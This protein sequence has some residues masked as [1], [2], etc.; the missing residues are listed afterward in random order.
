MS[1]QMFVNLAVADLPRAVAFF[2][3]LGFG[4]D[5]QFTDD[6]AT[7]MVVGSDNFVM[8]LTRPFFATFT[9]RPLADPRAQTEVLVCLSCASVAELDAMVAAAVA[10]G[11]RAPRPRVDHGFMVQHGFEDLDGHLWELVHMTGSPPTHA[12]PQEESLK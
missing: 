6:N 8:L 9:D 5:P 4:F 2:R 1:R 11:G 3:A 12:Q 7:C 10:A